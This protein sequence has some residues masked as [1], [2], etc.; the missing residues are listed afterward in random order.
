MAGIRGKDKYVYGVG[1]KLVGCVLAGG[2][3]KRNTIWGNSNWL[4]VAR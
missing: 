1:G 3:I 4:L 2:V